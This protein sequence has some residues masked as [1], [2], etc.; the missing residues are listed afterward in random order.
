MS[1]VNR[2]LSDR[3]FDEAV[4]IR[5]HAQTKRFLR[6][7]TR[8]MARGFNEAE[9]EEEAQSWVRT[10]AIMDVL[11]GWEDIKLTQVRKEFLR[12]Q[13]EFVKRFP[14]LVLEF[15]AAMEWRQATP[16]FYEYTDPKDQVLKSVLRGVLQ[17]FPSDHA[18]QKVGEYESIESWWTTVGPEELTK[19]NGYLRSSLLV[20]YFT[21]AKDDTT[22]AEIIFNP[23]HN[24]DRPT[25]EI[26]AALHLDYVLDKDN[27]PT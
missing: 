4:Q 24:R 20:L 13:L 14:R 10:N 21:M 26:L 12:G 23:E 15:L 1:I 7:K 2:L 18:Y 5:I 16:G 25:A 9:A 11:D 22:L 19:V 3:D 8:L 17:G 27:S 6:V